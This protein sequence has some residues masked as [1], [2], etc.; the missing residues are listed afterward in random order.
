MLQREKRRHFFNEVDSVLDKFIANDD[1]V[2]RPIK[3]KDICF[4]R[5]FQGIIEARPNI[6]GVT[7]VH[8]VAGYKIVIKRF[9]DSSDDTVWYETPIDNY[10]CKISEL[11]EVI[12]EHILEAIQR[13]S[14]WNQLK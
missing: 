2:K 5:P 14:K 7:S 3:L 12:H 8:Y 1:G 13:D 6:Y 4:G 11:E 9:E 10:H